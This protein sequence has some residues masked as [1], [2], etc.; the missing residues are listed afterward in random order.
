MYKQCISILYIDDLITLLI[1]KGK[2]K[3][4]KKLPN[5]KIQHDGN[6]TSKRITK[7]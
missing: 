6:V 4:T 7:E 1:L 2:K 5:K 3:K